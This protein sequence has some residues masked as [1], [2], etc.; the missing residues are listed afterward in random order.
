M[1]KTWCGIRLI[2]NISKVKADYIPSILESGKTFDNHRAIANIFNSF[3]LM[4]VK[5]LTKSLSN[6]FSDEQFF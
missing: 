4:W 2:S 3:L 5:T 1:K 6:L